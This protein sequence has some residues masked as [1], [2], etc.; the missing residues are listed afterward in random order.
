MRIVRVLVLALSLV[1]TAE[2]SAAKDGWPDTPAGAVGRAWVAAFAAGDSAMRQFLIQN[3]TR[4]SLAEKSIEERLET[5]RASR[6]RFGKL[7]FGSVEKS[8]RDELTVT[9]FDADLAPVRHVFKVQSK[10]PHRLISISRLEQR[11]GFHGFHH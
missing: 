2:A 4:E 9:L 10:P 5:Y 7:T 11:H 8:A 6:E 1:L 3:L